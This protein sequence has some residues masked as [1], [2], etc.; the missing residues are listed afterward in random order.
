MKAIVFALIA[1]LYAGSGFGLTIATGPRDGTYIQIARDIQR[2]SQKD[3]ISLE[4]LPTQG[5]F[6]NMVLLGDRKVDLA[7]AQIDALGFFAKMM[8]PQG[9][10]VF[11]TIR[12]VLHL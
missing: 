6:E 2:V 10:N 12:V 1:I 11:E 4:V 8:K 7:I 9:V 3:G 5:S